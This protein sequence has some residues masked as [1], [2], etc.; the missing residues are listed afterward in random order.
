ME[1]SLPV[2]IAAH[3]LGVFNVC[4]V[5]PPPRSG[6]KLVGRVPSYAELAAAKKNSSGG[7]IVPNYVTPALLNKVYSIDSNIGSSQVSQGVYETGD[8][9]Y[10]PSDLSAFQSYMGL[11][12]ETVAVDIGGHQDNN[13]CNISDC[14][15]G[16]L[17]VQYMMGVSQVTPTTYYFIDESNFMLDWMVAVASMASP[18]LVLSVSWGTY[19]S[20]ISSSYRTSVNDQAK[21]LSAMGVTLIAAS[22]DDG[23]NGGG[24]CGYVTLFPASC[25]YFTAV[26]ATNVTKIFEILQERGNDDTWSLLRVLKL[27]CQ[28]WPARATKTVDPS[29]LEVGSP[30]P[31]IPFLIGKHF[32]SDDTSPL[33][34]LNQLP[35]TQE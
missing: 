34:P 19:D 15:E 2:E 5:P 24:D 18:P 20:Y 17:D 31:R 14:F 23:V 7:T 16:N 27:V 3:L 8:E 29:P 22:G 35:V 32:K 9:Y 13:A 6:A 33:S 11:S 1:Y 21:I 26:G 12:Q 25:P 28:R 30:L 10:S 4:D